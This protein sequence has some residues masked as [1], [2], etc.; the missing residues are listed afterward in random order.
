M[1]PDAGSIRS[2]VPATTAV[3]GP[4]ALVGLVALLEGYPV[5]D[6]PL[7][8]L[9]ALA[10]AVPLAV[11]GVL[12]VWFRDRGLW[13]APGLAAAGVAGGVV[14]SLLAPGVTAARVGDAVVL[15]GEPVLAR[16]AGASPLLVLVVGGVGLV[17]SSLRTGRGGPWMGPTGGETGRLGSLARGLGVGVSAL[18]LSML[19]WILLEE[20]LS[21]PLVGFATLGVIAG[22]TVAG[23][24]WVR[25]RL[26]TPPAVVAAVGAA[27]LVGVAAGGSPRGFPLAWPVWILPAIALGAVEV[28]V[29]WGRRRF[30]GE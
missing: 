20:P 9:G 16:F 5:P 27:A 23:Y 19:P 24:L 26:R 2:A 22:G 3:A 6:G 13:V 18:A 11:L 15:A 14:G 7:E 30:A 8:L 17:E 10:P 12:G 29:R 1:T 21:A 4:P 28:T 25:H